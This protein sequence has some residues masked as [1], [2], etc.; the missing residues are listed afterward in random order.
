MK[1]TVTIPSAL[2]V[3]NAS[4]DEAT[5]VLSMEPLFYGDGRESVLGM[6]NVFTGDGTEPVFKGIVKVSGK[7]GQIHVTNRTKQVKPVLERAKRER[8]NKA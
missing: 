3:S 5:R 2:D 1:V 7:T 4:F 8:K 6:I